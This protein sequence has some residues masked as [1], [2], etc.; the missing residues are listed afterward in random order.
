MVPA[1]ERKDGEP[2]T[3]K[4]PIIAALIIFSLLLSLSLLPYRAMNERE[5]E[6]LAAEMQTEMEAAANDA[7]HKLDDMY[8]SLE[9]LAEKWQTV[10]KASP[11]ILEKDARKEMEAWPGLI[12]FFR[13]D[14]N[15]IVRW[16]TMGIDNKKLIGVDLRLLNNKDYFLRSQQAG[17]PQVTAI[18]DFNFVEGH[19]F[20]LIFPLKYKGDFDG[21]LIMRFNT[22][23][24]F[25]KILN[26]EFNQKYNI[27]ITEN[28]ALV[29]NNADSAAPADG[30]WS[31]KNKISG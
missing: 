30:Q 3:S 28:E 2:V 8:S 29:L 14:R 15:L 26:R 18:R 9:K 12:T 27:Y 7:S 10:Y 24:F 22:D 6:K 5:D 1:E 4:C 20:L 23:I 16:M 31:V 11:D 25:E 13:A 21:L 17:L 19:G